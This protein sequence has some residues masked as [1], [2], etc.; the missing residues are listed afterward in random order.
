MVVVRALAEADIPEAERIVRQAFGT[1]LG[2]PNLE[3]FW[4]PPYAYARFGA[5]P[6]NAFQS[7]LSGL[8]VSSIR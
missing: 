5:E 7:R 3:T 4:F 2:A 1:F 6:R 8:A